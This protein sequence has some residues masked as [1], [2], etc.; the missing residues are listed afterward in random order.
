MRLLNSI[1]RTPLVRLE[2]LTQGMD[3]E[4]LVKID[5]RNPGGSIKDR[6]ALNMIETALRQGVLSPEGTL[7]E[8][9]SGNMG[10]GLALVAACMGLK[11]VL[12]M[13]E[14]MSDERKALLRGFGAQLRLTPAAA[15]MGGAVEEAKRLAASKGYIL[16][17]QFSNPA[18]AEAHFNATGP[19]LLAAAGHF[20][21]FVAGVGT[22]G[23][24]TGTG[25]RLRERLPSV[26]LYAVEPA[27]SPLLSGG[28]AGPHA[29]Q[30]I[31]ANFVPA[32]L[33]RSLL[34]DVLPVSG[35]TALYTARRLMREEGISCGISSG[36][37]VAAALKLAASADFRGKRIVTVLPDTGE[38]YLST[39]LFTQG[40]TPA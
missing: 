9:T 32:L 28:K 3:C 30:G 6:P 17:D 22:G 40:D 2:R 31:G 7:V 39:P 24:L 35:E 19:E 38:R 27:E 13:P 4:I 12:T 11:L 34:N 20:D 8:P 33:D 37:N 16:L 1:G 15:G 25:R 26:G 5:A 23:T 10:I 36:A 29:I 14:S 21:A 18:N